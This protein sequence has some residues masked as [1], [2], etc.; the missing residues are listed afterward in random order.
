MTFKTLFDFELALANFTGAPY[1]VVTD[2]CTHAIELCFRFYQIKQTSFT[3]FTYLSIPMLM[4]QLEVEYKHIEESWRGEYL[5]HDTCIWDSAR[6]LEKNMYRS[7]QVQC[8]SF[9]QSKPL[10]IGR[11]GAILTDDP[12]LYKTASLWRSDGRDLNIKPW[13]SQ[14]SFGIG[15][16]FCPTLETCEV[17]LDKIKSFS[18]GI[19]EHV[20]PDLR[21]INFEN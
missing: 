19:T 5:F 6:R 7:G 16:H 8:L 21:L 18:G 1:A 13:Q 17:A 3:S 4:R 14:K 2:C 12:V 20:Y 9:G 10:Q 11:L 15:F